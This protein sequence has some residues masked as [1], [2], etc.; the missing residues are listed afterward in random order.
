MTRQTY[1]SLSKELQEFLQ[2]E[3]VNLSANEIHL[4]K[5]V[6]KS[7]DE[8]VTKWGQRVYQQCRKQSGAPNVKEH[9]LVKMLPQGSYYLQTDD[10]TSDIDVIVVTSCCIRRRNHFFGHHTLALQAMLKQDER[11]AE[12]VAISSASVPLLRFRFYGIDIDMGMC[13]LQHAEITDHLD[14]SSEDLIRNW[15]ADEESRKTLG[16]W[17]STIAIRDLWQGDPQSGIFRNY[18][19]VVRLLKLWAKRRGLYSN[20][21]GYFGGI[22]ISIL[23]GRI[24]QTNSI[25]TTPAEMV[26]KFFKVYDCEWGTTFGL[27]PFPGSQHVLDPSYSGNWQSHAMK[28]ITPT[29]PQIN[30]SSSVFP[31]SLTVIRQ[32]IQRGKQI[33]QKILEGVHHCSWSDLTEPINFW[34][35]YN[36]FLIINI[37]VSNKDHLAGWQGKVISKIRKLAIDLQHLAG[38]VR[39]WTFPVYKLQKQQENDEIVRPPQDQCEKCVM[40]F[41]SLEKDPENA[42]KAYFDNVVRNFRQSTI[43]EY[44]D[45]NIY[46]NGMDVKLSVVHRCDLPEDCFKEGN[47]MEQINYQRLG[48]FEQKLRDA[49]LNSLGRGGH[50]TATTATSPQPRKTRWHPADVSWICKPIA[51]HD[52]IRRGS[53]TDMTAAAIQI[54][55]SKWLLNSLR[56]PVLSENQS[57]PVRSASGGAPYSPANQ[58]NTQKEGGIK[59]LTF[60]GKDLAKQLKV[61]VNADKNNNYNSTWKQRASAKSFA[62]LSK[63]LKESPLQLHKQQVPLRRSASEVNS[64]CSDSQLFKENMQQSKRRQLTPAFDGQ[65]SYSMHQQQFIHP[66]QY[67][68]DN[69]NN[70]QGIK[71][72]S[73]Q[74][75]VCVLVE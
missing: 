9:N 3:G 50:Y 34:N 22:N 29:L 21:L 71:I 75:L 12:V 6:L 49:A 64:S 28:I 74:Q 11:A 18:K 61:I 68:K 27:F 59:G 23:V 63:L 47:S 65:R 14:Y 39:P 26:F 32:E 51:N 4:R 17:R 37:S 24:L 42:N 43:S 36:Y 19:L 33:C 73:F 31:S 10:P 44:M 60:Q 15:V 69:W 48:D 16:G 67:Q 38:L 13:Q 45:E 55:N 20:V 57:N 66:Q 72:H 35:S 62:D 8:I 41:L 46:R 7:L 30:S 70:Q 56:S 58:P 54:M 25:H 53:A 1:S 52:N 40:Y 2:R 5:H